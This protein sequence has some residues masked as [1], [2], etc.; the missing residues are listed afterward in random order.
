M[1]IAAERVIVE[2]SRVLSPGLVRLEDGVVTDVREGR[3]ERADVTLSDGVLAPG[4]IDLQVNGYFGVD[5]VDAD[6]GGW[7]RV[8]SRLPET[9]VTA[10][11]PTFITAPVPDLVDALRR[12]AALLPEA[13]AK[14]GARP[15]GV[16]VEGPFLSARRRGAHNASWLVDPE[17]EAVEAL[18]AAAPGLLRILTL[19]PE[20]EG[21]LAAI[22]RLT[23]AG[24]LASVG[25]SDATAAQVAGAADAGA[26]MV[27]HL[28]NGQ[29]GLHH[30]EPGV[31]GRALVDPRLS[32]GLIADLHHVAPEA[33]LLAFAAAPGR[34]YLTTD[35]AASAGMPPGRYELGGEPVEVGGEGPPLRTDGTMAG[36]GLRLDEAVA[37]MA[38]IGVDPL[39]AVDAATRV[40]A[41]L[42]CRRDLGRIAP[43]AAADLAWLGDDLRARATWV[44]GELAYGAEALS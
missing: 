34:V 21:S 2:G 32:C 20:R 11:V 26:R 25:H 12:T 6:A 38:G 14:G 13:T 40:P 39:T 4:L 5:L 41:D 35:A 17:P 24:V 19:A 9:G 44:G 33:C 31:V 16:H 15:L 29:R 36:S 7:R 8:L 28:F 27:T 1:L 42:V 22:R 43:G 18:L 23:E 3:A 30:R 37:N 10:F